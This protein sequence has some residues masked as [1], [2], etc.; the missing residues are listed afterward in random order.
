MP[1]LLG[2]I[3]EIRAGAVNR[4]G[5]R[6]CL[7]RGA[8]PAPRLPITDPSVGFSTDGFHASEAG[9]RAWAEHLL[10]LVLTDGSNG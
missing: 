2:K 5:E 10:D 4:M 6:L 8:V 9:Y 7:E 1:P 3:L